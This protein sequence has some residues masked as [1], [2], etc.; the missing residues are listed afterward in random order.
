MLHQGTQQCCTGYTAVLHPGTQRCYIR[1]TCATSVYTSLLTSGTHR[2]WPRVH[3]VPHRGAQC[4]ASWCTLFRSIVH[5]VEHA[6]THLVEHSSHPPRGTF[7]KFP[8][9]DASLPSML[10][11][12]IQSLLLV[13]VNVRNNSRNSSRN[14]SRNVQKVV[15][16]G[17]PE[18]YYFL[19][20][21]KRV[22]MK[23]GNYL[24]GFPLYTFPETPIESPYKTAV[25][26]IFLL[27]LPF[28]E[29]SS[30]ILSYFHAPFL[31]SQRVPPSMLS[32]SES[33]RK[34]G[35]LHKPQKSNEDSCMFQQ[36]WQE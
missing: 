8:I 11:G 18:S 23:P 10:W 32:T 26:H 14:S 21:R 9:D 28:L 24:M 4:S 29:V 15:T 7:L 35:F 34:L 22:S 6:V 30:R 1:Y 25:L 12:C 13:L 17:I 16:S 27:K 31:T 2:C 5:L 19:M 3:I 33:D 20:F 36:F